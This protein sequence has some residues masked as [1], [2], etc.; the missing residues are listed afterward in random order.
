[1]MRIPEERPARLIRPQ[2]YDP[3]HR[4]FLCDDS[5]LGIGFLC[6][7]LSGA[8]DRAANHLAVLINSAWPN[9]SILSFS[10]IAF[11]DIRHILDA[12]T[13]LRAPSFDPATGDPLLRKITLDRVEYLRASIDRPMN[14]HS[15]LRLR[16]F[17]IVVTAKLPLAT[18]RPTEQEMMAA[19]DLSV[20]LQKLLERLS[21]NE[22]GGLV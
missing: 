4:A 14:D 2:A 8:D 12:F 9:D 13:Q 10:L 3:V 7:P 22:R 17:V 18:P 11:P 15:H 6:A 16:D 1:M 20:E 21:R 5:S 19:K